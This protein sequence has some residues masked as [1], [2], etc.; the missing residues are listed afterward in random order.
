MSELVFLLEEPSKKA[1]FD[2]LLPNILFEDTVFRTIPHNGKTDLKK[3]IPKKLKACNGDVKFIIL[4]DKDSND[5]ISLK[6]N[7]LICV[8]KVDDL[9]HFL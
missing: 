6:M 5:C 8:E 3:S 1:F 2:V 7:L 9:I 4:Y